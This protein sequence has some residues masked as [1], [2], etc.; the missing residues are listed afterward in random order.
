MSESTFIYQ[1]S[2][3]LFSATGLNSLFAN[4]QTASAAVDATNT[5]TECLTRNHL[6][7]EPNITNDYLNEAATTYGGEGYGSSA[8]TI[9]TLTETLIIEAGHALRVGFNPLVTTTT[10]SGASSVIV[11]AESS[12]YLRLYITVGGVDVPIGPWWGYSHICAGSGTTGTSDA[13]QMFYE[14]LPLTALYLPTN[15]T[16]LTAIKAKILFD[17][18]DHYTVGMTDRYGW[19]HHAKF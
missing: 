17:D 12:W 16:T 1:K 3:G 15:D 5:R 13:K 19:Y 6:S 4:L 14:R 7:Q 9:W 18:P 8:V 10:V 11:R 2:R